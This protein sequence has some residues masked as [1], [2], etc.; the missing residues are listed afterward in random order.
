MGGLHALEFVH[1][2]KTGGTSIEIAASRVGIA[3]GICKF[4]KFRSGD[5][6]CDDI[7]PFRHQVKIQNSSEW[8]CS[9]QASPWHCPPL[10][11]TAGNK[12]EK[13]ETFAVVRNPYE[14]MISEYYYFFKSK[15]RSIRYTNFFT[16]ERTFTRDLNDPRFM[17]QWIDMAVQA[18]IAK[19]HCYNGH[20]VLFYDFVY[21]K[22]GRKV[23]SHTLK[24]ENLS[25]EFAALMDLYHLPIILEQHNVRKSNSTLGVEDLSAEVVATINDWSKRDFELFGYDMLDPTRQKSRE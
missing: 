9:T 11:Y 6:Q 25:E 19:G 21:A 17:N 1:I 15:L 10:K 8:K 20:C 14:R 23:V 2:P 13:A 4:A 5:P 7:R 12:F 22:D 3:W 18:A 16:G 24:M